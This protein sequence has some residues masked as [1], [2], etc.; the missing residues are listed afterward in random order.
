MALLDL[1]A[2]P[3]PGARQEVR[4]VLGGY[5]VGG[6]GRAA[7]RQL[8][9]Y[10]GLQVAED[11]HGDRARDRGGGHH[12][13]VRGLLALGPERVALLDAEAVLFVHD[14]QP[15]VVELHLV[16]DQRVRADDDPGLAGDQVEQGLP[17]R[18]HPHRPGEEHHLGALVGAAEHAAFGELPHHLGDRAVVLL[19]EDL[20]GGEHRRLPA[21]VHDGEH[22]PQRHHRLARADLALE[23]AVHGVAGREVVEDLLRDGLLALGEGEGQCGVEGVEEAAGSG[24]AGD[25]R[26][27]GVGVAAAGQGDLED[28]GLVPLQTLASVLDV[29]LGS[30]PV[31]LQQSL[32]ERYQPAPSRRAGGSGSTASRA[33]GSTASTHLAIFQDS[34]LAQ[35]G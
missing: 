30:R 10:G 17:A 33:P 9:E 21:G 34:S 19:G 24:A 27:L 29:G 2:D 20:G 22:R 15:E 12:E 11:G 13:Q 23:E 32:G 3:L 25:G 8:V 28:E 5:D 1:L 14:H 26:E 35:A 16:L 4:L 31:D 6:D 18:G 7:G